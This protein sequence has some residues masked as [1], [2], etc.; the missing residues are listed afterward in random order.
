MKKIIDSK[1]KIFGK[2]NILDLLIV[3]VI[4][5]LA[6]SAFVK[7]DKAEGRLTSDKTIEYTVKIKQIRQ[8]SVDAIN[9]ELTGWVEPDTKKE[10][11]EITDVKVSPAEELVRLNNGEYTTV[12][13]V[14]TYDAL[15]TMRVSGTETDDNFYTISGK[16][17]I[18]GEN[19]TLN[20][21]YVTSYG[22]VKS[23]KVVEQ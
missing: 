22:I 7:F 4:A 17:L 5:V 20:N 8:P 10:L 18:V 9:R 2:V 16:K 15:L 3:V 13:L 14:E 19:L 1:G 23:V 21:G 11:G 6:L 12:E